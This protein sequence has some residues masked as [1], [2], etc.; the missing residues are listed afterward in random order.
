MKD[1][2]PYD[3]A[4]ALKELGFDEPCFRFQNNISHIIEEKGWLNWN[5]V[6]QFV[7]LPLFSQAFRFFREKYKASPIITCYSELGNAWRYHIPN[8]G[9]EYDFYTYEEA[10]LACL[11]KLIDIVKTI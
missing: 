6:E 2:V 7:S 4:L 9:G 8:E 10:E 1:F 11:K 5:E 3:L